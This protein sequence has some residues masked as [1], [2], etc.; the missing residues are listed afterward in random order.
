MKTTVSLANISQAL[1]NPSQQMTIFS[2]SLRPSWKASIGRTCNSGL[3]DVEKAF[4]NVWH[5]GLRYKIYQLDLPTK[6]CRWL[7]DFLGRRV[8]QVKTEGFLSPKV[9][10]KAGVPQGSNLS[11]LLFLICVNDMP[12]PTYHQ[13]NKSQYADDTNGL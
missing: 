6:L 7:S 8:I 4:N 12:N 9:Y 10:L 3:L 13:A 11:P 2:A 1:G 5:N